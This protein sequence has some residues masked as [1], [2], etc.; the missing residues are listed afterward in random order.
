MS[1][2]GPFSFKIEGLSGVY[3]VA[4]R[5]N[6]HPGCSSD[7]EIDYHIGELKVYLDQIGAQMK[8]A[9]KEQEDEPVF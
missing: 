6:L 9:L 7:G 1:V 3:V 5:T 2:K 8:Q 4:D